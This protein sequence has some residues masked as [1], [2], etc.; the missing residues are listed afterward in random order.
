GARRALLLLLALLRLLG[1]GVGLRLSALCAGQHDATGLDREPEPPGLIHRDLRPRRREQER[2]RRVAVLDDPRLVCGEPESTIRDDHGLKSPFFPDRRAHRHARRCRGSGS[3]QAARSV[4]VQKAAGRKT[5]RATR[6]SAR[7]VFVP[8]MNWSFTYP[9]CTS[10]P[11][12]SNAMIIAGWKL[13]TR[14]VPAVSTSALTTGRPQIRSGPA[15]DG[16]PQR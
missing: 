16:E 8:L 3:H 11:R 7:I 10:I 14:P 6:M 9:T 5:T 4:T 15:S 12:R 1:R 2:R 13:P